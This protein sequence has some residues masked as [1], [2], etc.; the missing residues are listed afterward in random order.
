[1]EDVAMKRFLLLV[2]LCLVTSPLFADSYS[3]YSLLIGEGE[4]VGAKVQLFPNVVTST[5]AFHVPGEGQ[6]FSTL[7][8]Q[9][10]FTGPVTVSSMTWTLTLPSPA[11]PMVISFAPFTCSGPCSQTAKFIIPTKPYYTHYNAASLTVNVN[12]SA[13]TFPFQFIV[14]VPEPATLLLMG[15][16]IVGIGARRYRAAKKSGGEGGI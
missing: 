12:G 4:S 5:L 14:V 6:F 7:P 9:T 3:V 15:T 2:T 16:G 8:F 1:M 10:V 11:A 13:Q